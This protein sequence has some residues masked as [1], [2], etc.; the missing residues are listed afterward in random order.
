MVKIIY[1]TPRDVT[2]GQIGGHSGETGH[3]G[4]HTVSVEGQ[5]GVFHLMR[6]RIDG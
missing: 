1:T 6:I 5:H 2:L 3:P 4:G